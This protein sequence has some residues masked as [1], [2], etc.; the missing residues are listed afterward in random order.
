MID[1]TASMQQSFEFYEVDPTTWKDIAK[2]NNIASMS[3]DRDSS[4][5]TLGS[6]TIDVVDDSLTKEEFYI[7]AYL[8]A[9]QNGVT[10]RFALGTFLAQ[11]PSV[12]FD[13]RV[14]SYSLDAYTPL[15]EL[16]ERKP[17]I[18][19]YTPKGENILNS[20][21]LIQRAYSR[22]TI[23]PPYNEKTLQ[24]DFV[25]EDDNTWLTYIKDLLTQANYELYLDEYGACSYSPI[26]KMQA[27][28]PVFT[29]TD[30]NSSILLSDISIEKSYMS[31][32]NV[33]TVVYSDNNRHYEV[34]VKN[35]DANSITSIPRRGREIETRITD[36]SFSGE[37]TS[38]MVKEY[39]EQQLESLSTVTGTLKYKHGYNQVR[40]GDCVRVNYTRAGIKNQKAK[41]TSQSFDCSTGIEVSET[42][43]FTVQYWER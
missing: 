21:Y 1:W 25:A 34:T 16:T 37:P 22:G 15:I 2:L 17:Q 8:L 5:D 6:A 20:A 43:I 9:N 3:I 12:S 10:E 40:V 38:S 13:G 27:M 14:S 36:P 11:T 41:V 39:A 33:V 30:D 31:I 26:T 24:F 19:Y 18:G 35:E 28:T 32:P 4:A 29:Y 7:R 23:N 42:A